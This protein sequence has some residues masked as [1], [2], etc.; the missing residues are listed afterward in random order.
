MMMVMVMV[1][2][3]QLDPLRDNAPIISDLERYPYLILLSSLWV[4][5][6][7]LDPVGLGGLVLFDYFSLK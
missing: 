7:L 2:V 6:L 4:L 3:G 5:T 1:M